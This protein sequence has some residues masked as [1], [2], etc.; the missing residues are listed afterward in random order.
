MGVVQTGTIIV[1]HG[2]WMSGLGYLLIKGDDG[3]FRTLFCDNGPTVRALEDAFGNVISP[4]HIVNNEAIE[5]KRISY[6]ID[7][8]GLL[9]G[10]TPLEDYDHV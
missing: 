10:F 8:M 9:E 1:F 5:G 2:S 3:E 4:A 6:S 7:W